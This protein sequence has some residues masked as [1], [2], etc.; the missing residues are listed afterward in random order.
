MDPV[1]NSLVQSPLVRVMSTVPSKATSFV[2]GVRDNVPPFSYEKV[3]VQPWNSPSTTTQ[4]E[5]F[6]FKIP[7]RGNLN[8][9]YLRI[10]TINQVPDH[11]QTEVFVNDYEGPGL[12]DWLHQDDKPTNS[13]YDTLRGKIRIPWFHNIQD[14]LPLRLSNPHGGGGGIMFNIEEAIHPNTE[15]P[16][17]PPTNEAAYIAARTEIISPDSYMGRVSNAWNVINVLDNMV[18]KTN[19]KTIETIPGETIPA[20]VVKMP[21]GLRDFYIRGMVGWALGDFTGRVKKEPDFSQPWDPSSCHRDCYGR[22]IPTPNDT[23]TVA[24]G[25]GRQPAILQNQHVNFIV[26]VTL[27]S[28]KNMTKNYQT[29]FVEDLELDVTMKELARGFNEFTSGIDLTSHHEVELVLIYHTWHDNIENAIRNSNYSRGVPASIYSSDWVKCGPTVSP[30]NN[31]DTISIPIKSSHLITE[32]LIVS[33]CKK[34]TIDNLE[35]MDIRKSDYVMFYDR[36][37]TYKIELVGSGTTIW[38]GSSMELKGPDSADYD[39][40]DRRLTGGDCAYSGLSRRDPGRT[41]YGRRETNREYDQVNT[42]MLNIRNVTQCGVDYSFGDNM[43]MMRFGLQTTDE[44]YTG[45]LALQTITEPTI[46]ITPPEPEIVDYGTPD[47]HIEHTHT[48]WFD[49]GVEFQLYVKHSN[50]IRIDSDTG[51]ITK[52][53]ST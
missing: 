21:A 30:L 22:L 51:T 14:A 5:S 11:T 8:R 37:H 4:A 44:F 41:Q 36:E 47:D 20:E 2:H 52:T 27:S 29:S 13:S 1:I 53:L 24:R 48:G 7:R 45:G 15:S 16:F 50:L 3:V 18:L 46:K 6:R 31:T 19:G 49:R 32:L 26:P 23:E 12:F 17:G 10:K 33:R 43:V 39:L 42:Q 38:E 40:T 28:L 25:R 9:A 34:A 35:A